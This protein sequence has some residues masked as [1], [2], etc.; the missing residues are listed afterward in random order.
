MQVTKEV[1]DPCQV[2][3]TITVPSDTF[4][5][6][7]KRAMNQA[8]A[9]LQL[10]GFRKGK[11][12][13]HIAKGYLDPSKLA[14]RAAELSVPDAYQE[15]ITQEGI[16]PWADPNFEVL[17]L[18]ED[19]TLKFKATVPLRP[20]IT[21]GPYKGLEFEKRN[22][23]IR[24]EDVEKELTQLRE[25]F[26][27]FP[28][29]ERGVETGDII[30]CELQATVEGSELPDLAE[31][32]MTAIEVGKNIAEFD[33]G[34]LGLKKGEKKTIEATY[35]DDF[36][37]ES[38][39]GKK[40]TF[41][42]N[43]TEVRSRQVPEL[44]D[45][46]VQKAHRTAKTVDELK[47]AVRES[48]E[49]AAVEMSDNELEFNLISKIVENSQ[50]HFPPV[51]LQHE[52]QMEANQLAQ[53]LEQQKTSFEDYL[54]SQGKTQEIWREELAA[55]AA[56]RI[57]NSLALSEVARSEKLELTEEDLDKKIVERAEQI[58]SS[59]AA[60]R[61]LAESQNT[62]ERFRELALTEKILNFLKDSSKIT[63]RTVTSDELDSESGEAAEAKTEEKP[64]AKKAPAKKTAKAAEVEAPA[65]EAAEP[66]A[67]AEVEAGVEAPKAPAKRTRKKTTEE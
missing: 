7:T 47:V 33:Q 17:E 39:R 1:L 51:L 4:A 60:V 23:T 3:L 38:L 19:G 8:S 49:K 55:G 63:E 36:E 27:E 9:S 26:A 22:L 20:Q 44:T 54:A 12:P 14:Q 24:D 25:R 6:A 65:E 34:L 56:V 62:L 37:D 11:V 45:E 57:K 16:E 43:V 35:P 67:E 52:M 58:G 28:E 32:R 31:P 61:A 5:A 48:L 66:A 40:G 2:A 15:A 30:L 53:A 64:K 41:N 21:L 50:I 42:V 46:L 18:P 13:Q 29:V 59:P 10:P